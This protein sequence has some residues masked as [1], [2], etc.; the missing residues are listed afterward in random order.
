MDGGGAPVPALPCLGRVP[1]ATR[2]RALVRRNAPAAVQRA[3]SRCAP[4]DERTAADLPPASTA[5]DDTATPEDA[6]PHGPEMDGFTI[7]IYVRHFG[8]QSNN[9]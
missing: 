4:G 6:G 2:L 8:I 1:G 7:F 5:A 9:I 3:A